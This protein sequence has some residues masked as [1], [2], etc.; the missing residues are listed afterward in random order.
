MCKLHANTEGPQQVVLLTARN[1][2]AQETI[3][4][5]EIPRQP[6]IH[7]RIRCQVEIYPVQT[8]LAQ[9]GKVPERLNDRRSARHRICELITDI[10]LGRAARVR[11]SS[12]RRKVLMIVRSTG[13]QI[14]A[15]ALLLPDNV[16]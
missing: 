2:T 10:S 12:G 15:S 9:I 13:E 1:G 11:G 14:K 4:N 3:A 7:P 5:S 16:A 8:R 6:L